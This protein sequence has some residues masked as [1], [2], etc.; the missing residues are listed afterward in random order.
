L[1][2]KPEL[3]RKIVASIM[4]KRNGVTAATEAK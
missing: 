1:V 4:D 3:A 2:E